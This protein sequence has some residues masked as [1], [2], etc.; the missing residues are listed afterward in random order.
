MDIK[1]FDFEYR[2]AEVIPMLEEKQ[3]YGTKALIRDLKSVV[4]KTEE[5]RAN[6]IDEFAEK[7]KKKG[8]EDG[9]NCD[10]FYG[11]SCGVI[12][13]KECENGF[14]REID[15]IAEQLKEGGKNE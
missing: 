4:D 3:L 15:E 11:D 12:S 5:I 14:L 6:A 9:W 1:R 13:C 10:D 7:I 2:I 8:V